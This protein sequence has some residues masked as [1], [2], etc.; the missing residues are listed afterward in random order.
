MKENIALFLISCFVVVSCSKEPINTDAEE[1]RVQSGRDERSSALQAS[2]KSTEA[3]TEAAILKLQKQGKLNIDDFIVANIPGT[4]DP[5]L[6]NTAN[7]AI[8]YKEVITIRQLLDHRA[9]V[10]DVTTT[11]ILSTVKAPYAGENYIVYLQQAHGQAYKASYEEM[12]A[13]VAK[14]KLSYFKPG[15]GFHYSTTGYNLLA[16]II[17]RISGKSL[18]QFFHDEFLNPLAM[19]NPWQSAD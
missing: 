7:F 11:P 1:N 14:H 6:P 12:I 5:Y 18:H 13:V 8:P 15:A 3:F 2:M 16:V 19:K 9:G 4:N 17:E 10:F